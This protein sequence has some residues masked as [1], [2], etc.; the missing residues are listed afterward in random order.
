MDNFKFELGDGVKDVITGFTGIV[1]SR[2]QYI[3]GCNVY[4]LN[5]R[6][7]DQSG[8]TIDVKFLDEH[9]LEKKGK[10]FS[11]PVVKNKS[12]KKDGPSSADQFPHT[13]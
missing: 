9:R 3:T 13:K 2:T 8:N 1:E 10:K 6:K 4:G 12:N 7:L 5:S 11:L